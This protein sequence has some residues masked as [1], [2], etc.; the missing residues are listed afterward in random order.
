MVE[1]CGF[2]WLYPTVYRDYAAVLLPINVQYSKSLLLWLY[3]AVYLGCFMLNN[4][5]V[6]SGVPRLLMLKNM[7][8]QYSA[9]YQGCVRLGFF[10][11]L[12][13]MM[14]WMHYV[15]SLCFLH[16]TVYA[17]HVHVCVRRFKFYPKM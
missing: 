15:A 5:V 11:R 13:I 16:V 4:M 9:K 8:V 6:F 7:V 17:D 12:Y 10:R 14:F 2:P 3:S 1:F